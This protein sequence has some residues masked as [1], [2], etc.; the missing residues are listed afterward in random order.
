M[1][2]A[3]GV[4]IRCPC[5]GG[6]GQWHLTVSAVDGDKIMSNGRS[7]N[8]SMDW[9][10]G[11]QG[12]GGKDCNRWRRRQGT[13]GGQ[14][15]LTAAVVNKDGGR[16]M[17]A[18]ALNGCDNGQLQDG[19]KAAARQPRKIG[20]HIQ[21]NQMEAAAAAAGGRSQ[22]RGQ[23]ATATGSSGRQWQWQW[24]MRQQW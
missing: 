21:N 6:N 14:L 23:A 19:G 17:A 12:N 22:Q 1:T 15:H 7:M 20:R 3:A 13:D 8:M 2:V 4:D 5:I 11:W 24:H 10:R 9:A 16:L 18:A